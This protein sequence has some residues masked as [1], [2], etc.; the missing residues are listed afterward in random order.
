MD[1][2][3]A[4]SNVAVLGA[5]GKMGSGIALLLLQ[6]ISFLALKNAESYRLNLIDVN[7]KAFSH[8]RVYLHDQLLKF[9]E[10]NINFLRKAYVQNRNLVSNEDIIQAY[11]NQTLDLVYFSTELSSARHAHLIFEAIIEDEKIKAQ[12]FKKIKE[13]G[14]QEGFFLSNTS[15]IP[16]HELNHAAELKGSV[17]GFHFY[18]PPAV[19]RLIEII[20]FPQTSP[21]LVQLAT[22]LAQRLKKIIVYSRDVAGFIGNGHFIREVAFAGHQ[23]TELSKN[24]S[25]Q[26]SLW[27]INSVT[28]DWLI[29]PMGIFQLMDY[30]GLDV[31]RHIS[32]IMHKYLKD[33]YLSCNLVEEMVRRK[34]LGGQRPN[35]TQKEGFFLYGKQGPIGIY[36]FEQD[37][38]IPLPEN[39]EKVLGALPQ[40]HL[41]WKKLQKEPH[42]EAV[43]QSYLDKLYAQQTLG[44][45]LA[46]AFLNNSYKIS[47]LLVRDQVAQTLADVETVLKHGFYH[48]YGPLEM[49]EGQHE[50]IS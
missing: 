39:I 47:K 33:E 32:H 18:N 21:N 22:E 17:I 16:I 14:N 38:Y 48:L 19:Q 24:Y 13:S 37:K 45:Q 50:K 5:A 15:S 41:S 3:Q 4:L 34:I 35:G 43:L 12:V 23:V 26:E 46:Q 36:S 30:V 44:A 1:L 6:E 20:S 11:L 9:A 2:N 28:Q 10:K 27:M 7:E 42:K 8:L 31:C 29:R 49:K 25:L 40:G